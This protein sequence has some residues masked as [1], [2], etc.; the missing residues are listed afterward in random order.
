MP[1]RV[2]FN[3]RFGTGTPTPPVD[4]EVP[5]TARIG[6]IHILDMLV[7]MDFIYSWHPV[8]MAALRIARRLRQD[9]D[10]DAEHQ[11]IAISIIRE[12]SWDQFYSFCE[13]LF[14][15]LQEPERVEGT[16]VDGQRL[17]T[18]ALNELMAEENLAYEFAN[19]QFQR[20]GR[21]QT[22]RNLQRVS[23]V[24]AD[25][26]YSLVRNHYN[27]AVKFFNERPN[28]DVH[29]CVKEAVC[30]LE[31]F[32]TITFGKKAS[33]N[34]DE[35]I[36]SKQGNSEG[37]LPPTI[38]DSIIKLRAF[39]GNAQGVAHAAI[40]GGHVGVAEAEL[41][42]SLVATYITYLHDRFAPREDEIPF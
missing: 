2:P 36:R 19:G 1:M 10:H 42:L 30:A 33:R 24:L 13:R 11:D 27:K 38:G 37:Q 28:P 18:E 21:P 25:A 39:R 26:R 12:L 20:R 22:Q 17:F 14:E 29:N 16:L 5:D 7:S 9:F 35:C 8:A 4:G 23:T 15:C 32:A 41:V 40:D 31:A 34:F 3:R 6:L